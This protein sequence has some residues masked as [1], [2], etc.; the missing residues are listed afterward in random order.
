MSQ[1]QSLPPNGYKLVSRRKENELKNKEQR[2]HWE[3]ES[4]E[5]EGRIG[6]SFIHVFNFFNQLV[7][8]S[9]CK[10]SKQDL[11]DERTYS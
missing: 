1:R 5:E 6:Y 4:L 2:Q 9:T 3:L 11:G 7:K 10:A 8:K